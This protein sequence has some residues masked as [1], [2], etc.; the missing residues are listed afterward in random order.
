MPILPDSVYLLIKS[1]TKRRRITDRA[2]FRFCSRPHVVARG[3]RATRYELRFNL[4]RCNHVILLTIQSI[5]WIKSGGRIWQALTIATKSAKGIVG[6]TGGRIETE[7]SGL[8]C[9]GSVAIYSPIWIVQA[10]IGNR[11][12]SVGSS[13][14]VGVHVQG[15]KDRQALLPD[16]RRKPRRTG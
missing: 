5:R 2:I 8:D 15:R 16:L 11:G 6:A 12:S 3:K 10:N 9:I 14:A 1:G 4:P 7:F 13:G